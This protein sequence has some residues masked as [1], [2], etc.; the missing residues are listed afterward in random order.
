MTTTITH[1]RA[2]KSIFV[3]AL[4]VVSLFGVSTK[5]FAANSYNGTITTSTSWKTLATSTTGF[6][7]NVAV[8]NSSTGTDGLGIL[9]ADIRMLGKSGN[10]V[11][12]ES[13]ACPGY[14]T[15]I[16]WCG[17]DVYKI[18]INVAHSSG[19]AW[20]YETSESPN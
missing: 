4:L 16:F 11:W 5:A 9:R 8:V 1:K 10:V 2:L 14:G 20:A 7:C 18:Q 13:K 15:R 12:E 19:T 6:N 17:P 3:V